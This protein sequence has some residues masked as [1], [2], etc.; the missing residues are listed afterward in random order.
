MALVKSLQIVVWLS[1]VKRSVEEMNMHL[2]FEVIMLVDVI[3][4]DDRD[5]DTGDDSDVLLV[6]D[7]EIQLIISLLPFVIMCVKRI[8]V[9]STPTLAEIM[10]FPIEN[11]N[12]NEK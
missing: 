11:N 8:P 7:K 6:F 4:G 2:V 3:S 9:T 10:L 5:D 12:T 1:L